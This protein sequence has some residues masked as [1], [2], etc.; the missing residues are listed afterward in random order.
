[1][2][3]ELSLYENLGTPKIFYELFSKLASS[4]QAWTVLNIKEYFYNRNIDGIS[5][6]DGCLPFAKAVG[7]VTIDNQGLVSLNPIL[8]KSL[9]SEKHLS[10]RFLEIILDSL[11]D[12]ETFHKIF[13]SENISY[14]IIY[15]QIQIENGAFQFRYANFRHALLSFTFIQPHPDSNIR[16]LIV[17]HTYRKLFDS[18]LIPE[19]K[20]RKMG[21]EQLEKLLAQ[22]QI[23]GREA[24]EFVLNYEKKRLAKHAQVQNVEIISIYDVGAGY[25]II[26]YETTGSQNHDRFIEVKSFAGNPSFHWS[27]NE[28]D[29]S[30]VKRKQYFLYLIDRNQINNEGYVPLIIQNPHEQI[31]DKPEQ[32][33]RRVEDYFITQVTT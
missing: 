31:L 18:K 20:K 8:V 28:M 11:K 2:L 21:I 10:F 30:R 27:R 17:N 23:Y 19:I 15:K 25:D 3:N 9:S 13:C 1:M 32:W 7:A 24:E 6:F 4:K 22:K 12:D 14:D 29:V 33:E 26:S 5:I 16:K